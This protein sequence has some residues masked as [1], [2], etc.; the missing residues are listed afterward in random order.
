MKN[1]PTC[2]LLILHF[3]LTNGWRVYNAP[4]TGWY[5]VSPIWLVNRHC[6]NTGDDKVFQYNILMKYASRKY[7]VHVPWTPSRHLA[8]ID[9]INFSSQVKS[10]V[11]MS[12][13]LYPLHWLTDEHTS[14]TEKKIKQRQALLIGGELLEGAIISNT[15]FEVHYKH[16]GY[17]RPSKVYLTQFALCR[18]MFECSVNCLRVKREWSSWRLFVGF[19]STNLRRDQTLLYSICEALQLCKYCGKAEWFRSALYTMT[20]CP[21]EAPLVFHGLRLT[22]GVM[23]RQL[24]LHTTTFMVNASWQQTWAFLLDIHTEFPSGQWVFYYAHW[25]IVLVKTLPVSR[26]TVLHWLPH[27][28]CSIVSTQ[29]W[30]F[31]SNRFVSGIEITLTQLQT[32]DYMACESNCVCSSLLALS[33]EILFQELNPSAH[34][35]PLRCICPHKC[36][37]I[38]PFVAMLLLCRQKTLVW[39]ISMI[40]KLHR[41]VPWIFLFYEFIRLTLHH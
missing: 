10:W 34:L 18:S 9:N 35:S 11:A 5:P 1:Y 8:G 7:S 33:E 6:T 17:L 26:W 19:W 13:W 40:I 2:K 4:A 32:N 12:G 15:L 41:L 37:C 3:L 20:I 28:F 29:P 31:R 30:K 27:L 25:E 14:Q 16:S 36:L 23:I 22:G 24:I 21:R 38:P 39:V